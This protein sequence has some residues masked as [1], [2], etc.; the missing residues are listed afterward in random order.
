MRK[1]CFFLL[2]CL[3]CGPL[4][5]GEGV[6]QVELAAFEVLSRQDADNWHLISSGIGEVSFKTPREKDLVSGELTLQ[7][8]LPE[9][10]SFN[11]HRAWITA[12]FPAFDLTVGKSRLSW[13]EGGVFNAGDL[14]YGSNSIQ[15]D[16]SADVIRNDADWLLAAY[17]PLADF[18]FFETVILPPV[19]AFDPAAL[20][21]PV[22]LSGYDIA[23]TRAGARL[24]HKMFGTNFEAGYLF[25]VQ[26]LVHK[27]YV[28]IHGYLFADVIIAAQAEF[29]QDDFDRNMVEDS[30]L[31][32]AGVSRSFTM[33]T[34]SEL[35]LRLEGLIRPY[36]DWS[37]EPDTPVNTAPNPENDYALY[38][39]PEVVYSKGKTQTFFL[40]S[41]VSPLDVSARTG[42]GFNWRLFQGLELMTYVS[43][44]LGG[45]NDVFFFER[46]G[47]L[48]AMTRLRLTF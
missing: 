22:D 16:L 14:L 4:L 43:I 30:F 7:F 5:A 10:S 20:T 45:Q 27:P 42:T 26:T 28:S 35:S 25:D 15:A 21:E 38:L 23:K 2:V 24:Y 19:P 13:G 32:S 18:S 1:T 3:C 6:V 47:G 39:Y 34:D 9:M 48:N 36:A 8:I 33:G 46:P 17:L 12:W 31:I 40:R 29:D 37:L 11:I 41:V 44:D